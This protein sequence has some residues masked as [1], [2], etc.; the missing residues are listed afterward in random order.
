MPL[1]FTTTA[2]KRT[3][4]GGGSYKGRKDTGTD[5]ITFMCP[6]CSTRNKQSLYEAPY[7]TKEKTVAFVCK[8]SKCRSAVEVSLPIADRIGSLIISP[9]EYGRRKQETKKIIHGN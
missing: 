5:Y 8:N 6:A 1:T 7:T 9:A 3:N 2:L 4:K